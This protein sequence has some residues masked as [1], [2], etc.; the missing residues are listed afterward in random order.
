MVSDEDDVS[1][2]VRGTVLE[3]RPVRQGDGGVLIVGG[4]D[5]GRLMESWVAARGMLDLTG[6]WP[7]AIAPEWSTGFPEVSGDRLAVIEAEVV[8]M[9]ESRVFP[10]W[11]N[12]RPTP[13][14]DWH[15]Y[16]EAYFPGGGLPASMASELPDPVLDDDV[17][18]W[19]FARVQEDPIRM[20]PAEQ[21]TSHISRQE[22]FRPDAVE[23]ALLPTT[24]PW[25][26]GAWLDYFGAEADPV[27][28][29]AALQRWSGRW[30]AELVASWGT[31]LQF[32][33]G[34]RPRPGNEAW[35]LA[36]QLLAWGGSLQMSQWQLAVV[37]PVI[38]TWFLHDRP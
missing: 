26:A 7:V 29:V 6:R 25:L 28:L 1:S 36:G 23:L 37:L 15:A 8:G 16:L 12:D 27:A 21:L 38:D 19:V 13:Q 17:D 30:D 24:S 2:M 22:W 4:I 14:Q 35:E 18:R 3:G 5:P 31:M 20:M 11:V 34:R 10:R 9:A 33:V 32:R